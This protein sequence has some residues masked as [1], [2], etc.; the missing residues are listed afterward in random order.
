[1]PMLTTLRM[2]LPVCPFHAPLRTRFEKSAIRSST[3]WTSGHDVLAVHD[4]RRAARR[5]QRDVQH[6]A[7]LGHVD[8]VAAEHGVDALAQ[9]ALLGES[10]EQR[11][12]LVG[13]AVLRV[14]EVEAG[15]FRRQ[16]L[17]AGRVVGEERAQMQAADRLRSGPASAFH[18]GRAVSGGVSVILLSFLSSVPSPLERASASRTGRSCLW[19]DWE[20]MGVPLVAK[21]AVFPWYFAPAAMQHQSMDRRGPQVRR[22]APSNPAEGPAG[23]QQVCNRLPDSRSRDPRSM[24]RPE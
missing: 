14:V 16:A 18:A 2:R 4:D 11:Q 23:R 8:L 22:S 13:D 24:M 17:A 19:S 7:V 10:T 12:R 6:G 20:A 5:A 15:G 9:A 1:M 3:A 21:P